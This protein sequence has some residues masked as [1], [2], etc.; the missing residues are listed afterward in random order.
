MVELIKLVEQGIDLASAAERP[1]LCQRLEHTRQRLL[2][3]STRVIVV[4][5]FKQGKS[6]L[7]N[8]LVNAPVCPVDTDIA[9]SV[10]T[11]VRHGSVPA[12]TIFVATGEETLTA[13]EVG[14][15]VTGL[16]DVSSL[17]VGDT[18]TTRRGRS[19]SRSSPTTSPSGATRAIAIAWWPPRCFSRARSSPAG[20]PSSTPR[21]LAGWTRCT[22]SPR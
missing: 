22:R 19:R 18:L 3:Q 15:V 10:P 5:E 8:A 9:T 11:V 14:Y 13:G 4:G 21:A 1:D 12:A 20:C 6:Q 17:R 16:K 2:D 7:I